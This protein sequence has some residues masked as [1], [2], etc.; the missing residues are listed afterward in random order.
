[1]DQGIAAVMGAGVG[2]SGAVLAAWLQARRQERHGRAKQ[3]RA[4]RRDAYAA[5]TGAAYDAAEATRDIGQDLVDR[6][7]WFRPTRKWTAGGA[8]FRQLK[9]ACVLVKFE[10]PL[11]V[12]DAAAAVE[13]AI[14]NYAYAIADAR[15]DVQAKWDEAYDRISDFIDAAR[16][17]L[18]DW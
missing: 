4:E 7:K 12:S 1:M 15:S 17:S 10:G 16:K 2:M 5:F 18:S 13:E 3:L 14:Q 9:A 6:P 11:E 8:A